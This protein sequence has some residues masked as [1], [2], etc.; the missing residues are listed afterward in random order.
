MPETQVSTVSFS[1]FG[2]TPMS[3]EQFVA[4]VN[5]TMAPGLQLLNAVCE[6]ASGDRGEVVIS[7]ELDDRFVNVAGFICG[8]Y[9]AHILDQ[10]ATC[11]ATLVTGRAA[12]SVEFKTNF[13]AAARP[14]KFT[15]KGSVVRAGKSIAFTEAKM[16]DAETKLIATAAVTSQLVAAARLVEKAVSG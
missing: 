1:D 6:W 10:T 5:A 3:D 12:P 7:F 14:G 8:G 13:I 2:T 4:A 9:L 15:A 11:A 16:W